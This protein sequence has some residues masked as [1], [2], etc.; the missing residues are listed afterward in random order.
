MDD[1][2]MVMGLVDR[3]SLS[4][5]GYRLSYW[6]DVVRAWV[7]DVVDGLIVSPATKIPRT[8]ASSCSSQLIPIE[9]NRLSTRITINLK[10]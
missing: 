7:V 10:S 1:R 9:P 4:V 3:I 8:S 5:I 2:V 6:M